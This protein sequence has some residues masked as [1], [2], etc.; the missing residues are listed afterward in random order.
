MFSARLKELRIDRKLSQQQLAKA[1]G[2]SQAM[3]AFWEQGKHEP[4]E[5]A[6]RKIALYFGVTAD[7][8]LGMEK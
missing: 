6:I 7:Y 5:S 8:L 4:T 2:Y 1:L 3:I